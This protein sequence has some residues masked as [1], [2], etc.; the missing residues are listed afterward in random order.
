ML[1]EMAFHFGGQVA[2]R[3]PARVAYDAFARAI[4]LDS[5]FA[6]AYE[7]IADLA[8]RLRHPEMARRY[9]EAYLG[10]GAERAGGPGS[11]QP[12]ICMASPNAPP[13]ATVAFLDTA[14]AEQVWDVWF[15]LA[16]AVDSGEAAVAA[17]RAFTR[18]R[19]GRDTV[20]L[21][22]Q[23]G[24]LGQ[25]TRLPW[26]PARGDARALGPP[27]LVERRHDVHRG[28]TG[29]AGRRAA[30]FS[31]RLAGIAP[32]GG[33]RLEPGRPSPGGR[34]AAIPDPF[35]GSSGWPE[36]GAAP[37]RR[38]RERPNTGAT[39]RWPRRLTWPS[40]CR[41]T[42]LALT[43]LAALPDSLC[44]YCHLHRLQRAQLL[45]ARKQEAEAAAL[46]NEPLHDYDFTTPAEVLWALEQA[47]VS[48]HLGDRERAVEAMGSSPQPGARR[49]RSFSHSC[50]RPRRDWQG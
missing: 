14:K 49:T 16:S 21:E 20:D 39:R 4:E 50:E 31:R 38:E 47:R 33:Q 9:A 26:P 12:W 30:G 17:A 22:Q 5:A 1:G 6:P 18:S 24:V 19:Q 28:R 42:S 34:S 25:N 36:P 13:P 29:H 40:L 7:H 43:L 32:P 27:P 37:P 15:Y 45:S 2:P 10:I 41:D 11:G 48:E 23:R 44:R 46:L 8:L 35:A 3:V